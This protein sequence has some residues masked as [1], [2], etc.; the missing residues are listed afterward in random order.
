MPRPSAI[1]GSGPVDWLSKPGPRF[2]YLTEA[3][4][5][6]GAQFVQAQPQTR[7]HERR[8]RW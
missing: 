8:L 6:V 1:A 2:G 7:W 5:T 3:A 4:N